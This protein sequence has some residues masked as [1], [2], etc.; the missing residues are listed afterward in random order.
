MG[1]RSIGQDRQLPGGGS[2]RLSRIVLDHLPWFDAAEARGM[3][4]SDMIRLLSANGVLGRNGKPLSVG[5]L[6]ST[7]WRRR[8]ELQSHEEEMPS[9]SA[10]ET[11]SPPS[12]RVTELPKLESGVRTKLDGA[13]LDGGK[14]VRGGRPEGEQTTSRNENSK[15]SKPAIQQT[16]ARTASPPSRHAA[17]PSKK[18]V[19]A[20]M[21]RAAGVRRR[22]DEN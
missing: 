21:N 14:M 22:S 2:K 12:K 3:T 20:F 10:G 16:A 18:D 6:S 4:W 9:R 15:I 17:A 19:L 8:A 13:I 7:V 11:R 1:A 5:T